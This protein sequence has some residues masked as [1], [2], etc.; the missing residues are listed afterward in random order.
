MGEER[1]CYDRHFLEVDNTRC[2]IWS[3]GRALR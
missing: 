1:Q 2:V 3:L